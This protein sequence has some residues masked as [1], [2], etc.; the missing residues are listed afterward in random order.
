LKKGK[1]KLQLPARGEGEEGSKR[2]EKEKSSI[3]KT[4]AGKTLSDT[5]FFT[6]IKMKG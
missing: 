3:K 4:A 1:G 5:T 6:R 2:K